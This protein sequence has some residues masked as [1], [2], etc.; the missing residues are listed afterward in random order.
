MQFSTCF[1]ESKKLSISKNKKMV[2]I[3]PNIVNPLQLTDDNTSEIINI[4]K[5]TNILLL[6][7]LTKKQFKN[8][9]T[10]NKFKNVGIIISHYVNTPYILKKNCFL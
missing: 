6:T 10:N 9:K 4:N 7:L 1:P 2:N 8:H 3:F 5:K